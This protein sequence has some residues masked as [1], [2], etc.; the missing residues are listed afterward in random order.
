[1]KLLNFDLQTAHEKR[2]LQLNE[3]DEFLNNAYENAR[4]Y[5]EKTT[6]WHDK[7]I[8]RHE[9]MVG[10]KLLYNSRLQL[11]PGKLH[12]RWSGPFLVTQVY[13]QGAVEIYSEKKGTFK[14]NGQILKLYIEGD[15]N[16]KSLTN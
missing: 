15:F 3:M 8:S 12:S 11:F 5:K 2:L 13:P 1:M 14:V 9:F 10:Q 16:K 7:H 6:M 4:I